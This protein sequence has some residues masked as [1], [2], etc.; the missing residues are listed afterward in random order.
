L[1][2]GIKGAFSVDE[3]LLMVDLD[4][5]KKIKLV[6]KP[7]GQ[8]IVAM[9]LLHTNYHIVAK[10]DIQIENIDRIPRDENVIF[11]MNHTDRFNYWPFQYKLWSMK[12]FS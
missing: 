3:E 1:Q 10:V 12:C 2:R 9:F 8:D 7:M 4:Y 6:S 5:L 11:A